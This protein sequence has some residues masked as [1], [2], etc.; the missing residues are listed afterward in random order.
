MPSLH[1]AMDPLNPGQFYACCGLIE[2]FE[3]S[4]TKILSHFELDPHR[5]RKAE[6]VLFS[7]DELNLDF[8]VRSSEIQS[9]FPEVSISRQEMTPLRRYRFFFSIN[10][11]SWIGGS[12]TFM[13]G[14]GH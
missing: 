1:I 13:I 7:D 2:L 10:V 5:P 3:L 11:L 4:G 6:F 12:T 9:A 14:H 8:V